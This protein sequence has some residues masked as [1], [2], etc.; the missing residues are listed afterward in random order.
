M[1]ISESPLENSG[2]SRVF[3]TEMDAK[4]FWTSTNPTLAGFSPKVSVWVLPEN[5]ARFV[6]SNSNFDSVTLV[7]IPWIEKLNCF[8]LS[9]LV[10]L[11]IMKLL[12]DHALFGTLNVSENVPS[13]VLALLVEKLENLRLEIF[14]AQYWR[15]LEIESVILGLQLLIQLRVDSCIELLPAQSLHII[16]K[17]SL[18]RKYESH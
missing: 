7:E 17:L 18:A 1:K 13:Y 2:K 9:V 8:E 5:S 4:L 3:A 6:N 11:S 15:V 10:I 12:L 16:C 14:S